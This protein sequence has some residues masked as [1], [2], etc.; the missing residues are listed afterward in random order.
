MTNPYQAP[1]NPYDDSSE[2]QY[3]EG[4]AAAV[5]SAIYKEL[6]EDFRKFGIICMIIYFIFSFAVPIVSSSLVDILFSIEDKMSMIRTI[7]L[8]V[9]IVTQL[10]ANI[11]FGIWLAHLSSKL[12]IGKLFG[13]FWGYSF[14]LLGVLSFYVLLLI[15]RLRA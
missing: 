2:K 11:G 13:F 15:K 14:G 3:L 4:R 9:N 6:W 5:Y 8:G 1:E 12:N 7:T 10:F